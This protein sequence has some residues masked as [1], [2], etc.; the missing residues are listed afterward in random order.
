VVEVPAPSGGGTQRW[1]R[2]L[3]GQRPQVPDIRL[4]TFLNSTYN[5]LYPVLLANN[6]ARLTLEKKRKRGEWRERE[7]EQNIRQGLRSFLMNEYRH[8]KP[9][10]N[11]ASTAIFAT[12]DRY[13]FS[14][15]ILAAYN[16]RTFISLKN[17]DLHRLDVVW[18]G[19]YGGNRT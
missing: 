2:A 19:R 3:L 18:I 8:L 14:Y 7:A 6:A 4:K 1:A 17:G 5:Y 16:T 12:G 9:K 10:E 15:D 13:S 11:V